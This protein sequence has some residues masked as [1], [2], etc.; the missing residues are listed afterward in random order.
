MKTKALILVGL[1]LQLGFLLFVLIQAPEPHGAI[2]V[3]IEHLQESSPS[4]A[5]TINKTAEKTWVIKTAGDY[6]L[7]ADNWFQ[8]I[9][10]ATVCFTMTNIIISILLFVTLRKKAEATKTS[11]R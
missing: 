2:K 7:M 6:F 8:F 11:A 3:G 4:Q 9:V 5:P 1:I 10:V